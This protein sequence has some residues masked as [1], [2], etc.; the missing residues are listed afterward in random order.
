MHQQYPV[1]QTTHQE[2]K[3]DHQD[4]TDDRISGHSNIISSHTNIISLL[5]NRISSHSKGISCNKINPYS[6][7]SLYSNTVGS[8][9]DPTNSK[10][11]GDHRNKVRRHNQINKFNA[12]TT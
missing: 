10:A 6:T 7:I 9:R 5:N 2:C 11:I 1:K 8:H 3:I 4:R 12:T